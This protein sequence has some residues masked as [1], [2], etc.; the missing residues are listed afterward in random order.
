MIELDFKDLSEV[1]DGLSAFTAADNAALRRKAVAAI[2][3]SMKD[4]LGFQVSM[5]LVSKAHRELSNADTLGLYQGEFAWVHAARKL[6]K[7]TKEI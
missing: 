1:R 5:S 2:M 7:P 3:A 4:A 6:I